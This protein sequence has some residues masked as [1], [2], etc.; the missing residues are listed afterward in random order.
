M[1]SSPET[2]PWVRTMPGCGANFPMRQL[3][4]VALDRYLTSVLAKIGTTSPNELD[5]LLPDVWKAEVATEP[6]PTT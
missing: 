1:G 6:M 4:S 2:T 5:Q 3:H